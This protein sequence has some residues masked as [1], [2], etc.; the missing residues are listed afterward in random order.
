MLQGRKLLLEALRN[1]AAQVLE[2]VGRFLPGRKFHHEVIHAV[3]H[4]L[5]GVFGKDGVRM[6]LL[7]ADTLH[8]EDILRYSDG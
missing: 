3:E 7:P 4:R 6:E 8:A 1:A 5:S 2:Q